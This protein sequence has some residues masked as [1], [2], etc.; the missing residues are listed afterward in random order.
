MTCREN[1]DMSR[2]ALPSV[3]LHKSEVTYRDT[4]VSKNSI[5]LIQKTSMGL[6]NVIGI[7]GTFIAEKRKRREMYQTKHIN[8]NCLSRDQQI[9]DKRPLTFLCTN[10]QIFL[11]TQYL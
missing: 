3:L 8:K 6:L 1:Y 10:A 7:K 5:L 2:K 11:L 4:G 9:T